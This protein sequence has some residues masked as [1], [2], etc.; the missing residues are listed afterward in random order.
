MAL[1]PAV[2]IALRLT[3]P[4]MI[5]RW[6]LA[7]ALGAFAIDAVDVILV[8]ALGSNLLWDERYAEIDK[9][10][11]TYYLAIEAYVAWWWPNAWARLPALALFV[12]RL[13]GAAAYEV[14]GARW[15]LFAFPNLFENWWLYCLLVA[16]FWPRL[17]PRSAASTALPLLLLAVPKFVQEYYLHIVQVHPWM[18]A[19]ALLFGY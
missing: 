17:S 13:V 9:A 15:L 7:G 18:W 4:L 12:D 5:P 16:T 6:P 11:D 10:L 14:T 3:Q 1:G 2:L 8:D 19:R